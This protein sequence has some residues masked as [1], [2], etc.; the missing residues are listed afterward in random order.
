MSA[1]VFE[2][3]NE[4]RRRR[5]RRRKAE[6]V[7]EFDPCETLLFAA[8]VFRLAA[9][10]CF[11]TTCLMFFSA[12]LSSSAYLIPSNNGLQLFLF[13]WC[14]PHISLSSLLPYLT[15]ITSTWL[16]SMFILIILYQCNPPTFFIPAV[17]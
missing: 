5:R 15:H 10:H 14:G 13:Y 9:I 1:Q 4:E 12:S 17:T 11:W 8:Q 7:P 16:K 6:V 2:R 3:R